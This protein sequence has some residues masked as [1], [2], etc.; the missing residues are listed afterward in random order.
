M[1]MNKELDELEEKFYGE[2]GEDKDMLRSELDKIHRKVTADRDALNRFIVQIK[3]RF[4]GAYIPYVFWDKL[5]EFLAKPEQ[6]TYLYELIK[7]FTNS[8]FDEAEQKK[9]KPLL[10]TYFANEKQFEIDKVHTLVVDKAHPSVRDYFYK[11][12]NFVRKN[13]RSTEMY[14]DKFLLLKNIYPD[15]DMMDMPIT[16]LRDQLQEA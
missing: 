2:W 10:I 8:D 3:D 13:Q 15:F 6:R 1:D 9:M 5:A 12:F 7:S 11:L 4:G 14:C 16:Q